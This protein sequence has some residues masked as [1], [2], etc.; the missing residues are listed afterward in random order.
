M[1]DTSQISFVGIEGTELLGIPTFGQGRVVIEE[2][3]RGGGLVRRSERELESKDSPESEL[4]RD[5]GWGFTS[6]CIVQ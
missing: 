6:L 5:G 3:K 4:R 1:T 2:K